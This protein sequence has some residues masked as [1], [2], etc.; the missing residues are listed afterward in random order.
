MALD[1]EGRPVCLT[2][3][4]WWH[5]G[6]D[7]KGECRKDAPTAATGWPVTERE[8]GCGD[9]SEYSQGPKRLRSER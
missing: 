8:D 6:K 9:H 7:G 4:W 3:E 1:H 5:N 2:C